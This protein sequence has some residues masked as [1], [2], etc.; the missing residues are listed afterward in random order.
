MKKIVRKIIH[1]IGVAIKT[2]FFA[3]CCVSFL[4]MY[5]LQ[6]VSVVVRMAFDEPNV[7]SPMV[8][9]LVALRLVV[10]E[11]EKTIDTTDS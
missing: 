9:L 8:S 1:Y 10:D 11:V 7:D 6:L 4:A 3:L 2:P 5:L